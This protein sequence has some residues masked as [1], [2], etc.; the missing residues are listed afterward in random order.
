MAEWRIKY[1]NMPQLMN[2]QYSQY[3]NAVICNIMSACDG[4]GGGGGGGAGLRGLLRGLH[5]ATPSPSHMLTGLLPVNT[6]ATLPC[7]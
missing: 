7:M 4:S 1:Y 3:L 5:P 2:M 6:V